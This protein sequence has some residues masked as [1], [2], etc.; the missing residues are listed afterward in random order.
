M[1]LAPAAVHPALARGALPPSHGSD[2]TDERSAAE[3]ASSTAE[4]SPD[5]EASLARW[6]S[7]LGVTSEALESAVKAVGP[8]I[9]KIKDYLTGG[10]AGDQEDA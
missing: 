1:D 8:R 6:S 5:D 10:M 4:V 9:D 2:M 7:A 3:N